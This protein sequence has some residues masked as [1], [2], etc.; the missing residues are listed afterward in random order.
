MKRTTDNHKATGLPEL[1]GTMKLLNRIAG[2]T[3]AIGAPAGQTYAGWSIACRVY[4]EG[5]RDLYDERIALVRE[6]Q[7]EYACMALIVFVYSI[8]FMAYF[9]F[10]WKESLNHYRLENL[11]FRTNAFIYKQ[12]TDKSA[13]KSSAVILHEDGTLGHYN[14]ANRSI[15]NFL[16][17]SL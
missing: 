9:S 2:F 14:R 11:N 5:S 16:E 1:S 6:Y 3:I 8:T 10:L 15:Y 17:M 7:L 13:D 4:T 12:A